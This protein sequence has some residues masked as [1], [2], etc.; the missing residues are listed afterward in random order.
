MN[1]RTAGMKAGFACLLS[2]LTCRATAGSTTLLRTASKTTPEWGSVQTY[3]GKIDPVISSVKPATS[4]TVVLLTDSLRPAEIESVKKDLLELYTSLHGHAFRLGVLGQG[5]LGIAGPFA[6][7]AQLKSALNEVAG[8]SDSSAA[9]ASTASVASPALLDNLYAS[10]GQL[11]ANWSR[12]LLIGDLPPLEPSARE[13]A[14]GLLLRA[15]GSAHLQ[16]SW[17]AFSGG[18]DG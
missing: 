7:R 6:S 10:V 12:V 13:Y 4:I 18:N 17:Y 9:T 5:A 1:M 14:S 3:A 11:G 16:V 8:G 2:V 15:F